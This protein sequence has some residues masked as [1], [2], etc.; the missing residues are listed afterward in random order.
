MLNFYIKFVK[1]FINYCIVLKDSKI[2]LKV[3]W[4][5]FGVEYF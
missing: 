4:G 1:L 2:K 3:F 5:I